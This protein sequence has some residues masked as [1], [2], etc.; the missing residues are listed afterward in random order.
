MDQMGE[1]PRGGGS[2]ASGL[3]VSRGEAAVE[4]G[5]DV[6][7]DGWGEYEDIEMPLN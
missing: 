1:Q 5:F 2:T 4:S 3:T 6:V 7:V